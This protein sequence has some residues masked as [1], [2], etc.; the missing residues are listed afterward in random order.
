MPEYLAPGV[1]VEEEDTGSKPIEGVSTSTSGMVGVTAWGP[2]NIATLVTGFADFQRQFGGYLDYRKYTP[3]KWY[4]PHAVEG[5]FTNGGKRLYIVRV[6][7]QKA[8]FAKTLLFDRGSPKD[9]IRRLAVNALKGH[10]L[11]LLESDTS[12]LKDTYLRINDGELSEYVQA[13]DP[14]TTVGVRALRA[15][16]YFNHLSKTKVQEV[17]AVDS[18]TPSNLSTTLTS[19][20]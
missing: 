15:P 8:E 7:P 4:L 9:A 6:L 3:D 17:T 2:E 11:L 16:L 20:A 5:F 14:P 18:P 10:K 12:T 19:K 13:A 1:Y